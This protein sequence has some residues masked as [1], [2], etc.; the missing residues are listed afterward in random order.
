MRS[1]RVALG[2]GLTLT[3]LAVALVL[4]GSPTTVAGSNSVPPPLRLLAELKGAQR[5][6][7]QGGTVPGGTSAIRVSLASHTGPR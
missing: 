7:E 4:S 6:C 1:V 3:L 5:L 2:V